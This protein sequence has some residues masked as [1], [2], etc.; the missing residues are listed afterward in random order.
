MTRLTTALTAIALSSLTA[1]TAAGSE[2]ETVTMLLNQALVGMDSK[3]VNLVQVDVP[4]GFETPRHLHPGHMF[5]YVLEGSVEIDVEGQ[6]TVQLAAGEA[7]YEIPG[8]PMIGR[9]LS[10]TEGARLLIFAL[11]DA[12]APIELPAPE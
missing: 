7:V 6:P 5:M 4:A 8:I 11:G 3:E 12:G 10:T 1:G 2:E 9:N